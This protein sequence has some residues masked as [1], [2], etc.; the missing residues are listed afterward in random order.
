[1]FLFYSV[2]ECVEDACPPCASIICPPAPSNCQFGVAQDPC[3]CCIVCAKGEGQRCHLSADPCGD[4]L[5]CKKILP[6]NSLFSVY[7]ENPLSRNILDT[8][9]DP[10]LVNSKNGHFRHTVVEGGMETR[11]DEKI[12]GGK[13]TFENNGNRFHTKESRLPNENTLLKLELEK[14]QMAKDNIDDLFRSIFETNADLPKLG[15]NATVIAMKQSVK[16]PFTSDSEDHY[17]D[18][19]DFGRKQLRENVVN[20]DI[21]VE[22]SQR[23]S[24][25]FNPGKRNLTTDLNE[26]ISEFM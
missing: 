24:H 14:E 5:T 13:L 15:L 25:I 2:V 9:I 8:H 7:L 18:N 1:L 11:G 19:P 4:G 10:S 20:D 3:K 26:L 12:A 16:K 17:V 23:D 21:S 6:L 22:T